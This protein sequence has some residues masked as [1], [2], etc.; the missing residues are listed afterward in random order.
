MRQLTMSSEYEYMSSSKEIG[1]SLQ[2]FTEC[3]LTFSLQLDSHITCKDLAHKLL[4]LSQALSVSRDEL[5]NSFQDV[6]H[7]SVLSRHEV[8]LASHLMDSPS[9]MLY[10]VG[11]FL[12]MTMY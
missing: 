8:G 11:N 3:E 12:Y 9:I 2:P 10:I 1:A 4:K 6:N 5:R 7:S